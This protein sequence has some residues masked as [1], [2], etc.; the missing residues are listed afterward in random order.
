MLLAWATFAGLIL[1]RADAFVEVV[2]GGREPYRLLNTGEVANQQRIRFTNQ[3]EAAQRF[4]I[5]VIEPKDISLVLSENPVVVEAE[6]VVTVNAVATVPRR[7]FVNGQANV[8]YLVTS[9]HGFRK[10]LR[11]LLLGPFGTGDAK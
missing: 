6:Q 10:E 8:R 5:E 4:S 2:R 7:L 9:D 3:S 1:T 11:F